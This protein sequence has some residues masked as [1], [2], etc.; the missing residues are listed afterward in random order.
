MAAWSA[1]ATGSH[2]AV[3]PWF[4][5]GSSGFFG[6][7]MSAMLYGLILHDAACQE[8]SG[9]ACCNFFLRLVLTQNHYH[10]QAFVVDNMKRLQD[11]FNWLIQVIR[12]DLPAFTFKTFDEQKFNLR[13]LF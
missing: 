6:S 1:T 3:E 9:D 5:L 8:S 4:S 12:F 13:S 2:D 11:L 10:M 7:I